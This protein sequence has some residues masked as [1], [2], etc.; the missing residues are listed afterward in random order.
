MGSGVTEMLEA[1]APGGQGLALKSRNVGHPAESPTVAG[2]R[3]H[4]R[5]SQPGSWG[6]SRDDPGGQGVGRGQG[7]GKS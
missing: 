5:Q 4:G 6:Q 3:T 1:S 7:P 2:Q